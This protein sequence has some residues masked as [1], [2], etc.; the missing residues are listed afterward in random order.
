MKTRHVFS[1]DDIHAVRLAVD[2]LR[3]VGWSDD[4]MERKQGDRSSM[5]TR[6][7]AT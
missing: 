1:T 6:R 4:D 7:R 5:R 2:A 3:R